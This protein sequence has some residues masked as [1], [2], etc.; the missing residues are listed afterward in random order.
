MGRVFMYFGLLAALTASC[1]PCCRDTTL[2]QSSGKQ[3]AIVAVLPVID[4]SGCRNLSWNLSREFTDEIRNRVYD[5]SKVY[6]LRDHGSREL[7]ERL[8]TP[9]PAHISEVEV[10]NLGATEFVVVA[11]LIDQHEIPYAARKTPEKSPFKG[12]V[13]AVL[14]VDM[15]VRVI[16]IRHDQPKVVLQEVLNQEH[17]IV[18]A[19][20]SSDYARAPWGTEAFM[21]TPMGL[22]HNKMVRELV[23]R[24]E[25]YIEATR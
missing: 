7:A 19:Y 12:E 16:D 4:H 10:R 23:S 3:K 22:T 25:N 15:R 17:V 9:N 5:S 6:L 11:E 8:N 18:P 24:V 1:A 13:S 2:Y 14:S 21:R 20:M